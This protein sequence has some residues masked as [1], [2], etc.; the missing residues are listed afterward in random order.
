MTFSRRV[1]QNSH[2][3]PTRVRITFRIIIST[4]RSGKT[5]IYD[6]KSCQMRKIDATRVHITRSLVNL[7]RERISKLTLARKSNG[8]K[9]G[10]R[11]FRS[12]PPSHHGRWNGHKCHGVLIVMD[13]VV[14]FVFINSCQVQRTGCLR[15]V[16]NKSS[17]T[18]LSNIKGVFKKLFVVLEIS[19]RY[20]LKKMI[21]F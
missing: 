5:N 9:T 7:R 10:R 20:C 14:Q 3:L 4:A 17:I 2:H 1:S 8:H 18:R 15:L 16:C 11:K 6:T 12:S 13:N 21:L 19:N